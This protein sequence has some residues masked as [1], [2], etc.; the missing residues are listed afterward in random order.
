MRKGNEVHQAFKW[1]VGL[2]MCTGLL[3]AWTRW[4]W[5]D[6]DLH[7]VFCDVGQGDAILISKGLTQVLI[8]SGRNDAVLECL[9]RYL[10]WW[11]R[12]LELIVVTHADA[13]HIGG[14]PTVLARYQIQ[15][16]LI[17]PVGKPSQD[18]L[19]LREAL[20]TEIS[21][22]MSLVRPFLGQSISLSDSSRFIVLS[23][24][25]GEE[26]L[27]PL[28][29]HLSE[30]TLSDILR[31]QEVETKNYNDGSIVLLLEVGR[32]TFL[33]T[34]DLETAGEQALLTQGLI[35]DVDILK[36]GH[37]GS[38]TSTSPDFL[39][40]VQPEISVISS[41]K[42]NRYGH[43]APSVL[44]LLEERNSRILRTDQVGHVHISTNGVR[45]WVVTSE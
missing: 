41:G 1:G 21:Q 45:Y 29:A 42:N 35:P 33:L 25:V 44:K 15:H 7:V 5:P 13:D 4:H 43:P 27:G 6:N 11:D 3:V 20:L 30:A 37:H 28:Q 32:V 40:Q 36:V 31:Q 18:F 8:D 24:R 34:G 39:S 10:P 17:N 2:A 26:S 14:F 9:A 16:A 12:T 19:A 23:P 22:G 38:K